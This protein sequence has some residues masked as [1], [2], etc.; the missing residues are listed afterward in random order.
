M[1]KAII[2]GKIITEKEVLSGKVLV[3]DQKVLAIQDEIPDNAQ[4]ID[5]NGD[6]VSAGFIDIHTHG[7]GGY[8][9]ND[10]D[11]SKIGDALQTYIKNGVTSVYPTLVATSYEKTAEILDC[12]KSY[13]D[14]NGESIIRGVHLEGPYL[15][16]EMKGAIDERYITPPQKDEYLKLLK[17]YGALIKR[18]TYA[19]END[20]GDEFLRALLENGVIPS[21]GHTQAKYEDMQRQ[22]EKGCNLITHLYS[23]TSTITREKGFR[24]LGVIETTELSDTICAEIIADGKHVPKELVQLTFKIMGEDRL[25]FCTDS[26]RAAGVDCVKSILGSLDDGID[27]LVE[28][29]VAKLM[30]RSAFAGSVA[31]PSMMLN[32]AVNEVGLDLVTAVKMLT[33]NPAKFIKLNHKG[34]LSIGN[35]ADIVV[36]DKAFNINKT[37]LQGEIYA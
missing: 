6:F 2:N 7:A 35:D 30:D 19:P 22:S 14:K 5:A 1:K 4:I 23:C 8:D 11:E 3:F 29:G 20:I 18:W 21:A 15:A 10:R 24:K 37:F 33:V 9:F 34:S 13:I 16:M 28:D 25:C 31:V 27:C 26:M 36:F 12:I 17:N 32:F